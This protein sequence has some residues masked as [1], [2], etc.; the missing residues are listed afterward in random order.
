MPP[1]TPE[2]AQEH[3]AT[4]IGFK[5]GLIK[6]WT[7]VHAINYVVPLNA[8]CPRGGAIDRCLGERA[9]YR[10]LLL[11]SVQKVTTVRRLRIMLTM[12]LEV[13]H[14]VSLR[15]GDVCER[16]DRRCRKGSEV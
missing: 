2:M 7:V 13:L 9:S 11:Q 15:T 5:A 4:I 10:V 6:S 16:L 1:V 3:K 8:R 12:V 14:A